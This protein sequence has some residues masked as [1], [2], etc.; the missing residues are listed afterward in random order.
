MTKKILIICSVMMIFCTGCSNTSRNSSTEAA[1]ITANEKQPVQAFGIVKVLNT[2]DIYLDFPIKIK[3]LLVKDGQTITGGETLAIIDSS[4]MNNEIQT[5]EDQA[6]ELGA[7]TITLQKTLAQKRELIF[8][9]MNPDILKLENVIKKA[10]AV[11]DN[12]LMEFTEKEALM[13]AGA[14]SQK[15]YHDY[16]T[17]VTAGRYACEDA[18][19]TLKSYKDALQNEFTRDE[20]AINQNLSKI[21]ALNMELQKSKSKLAIGNLKEN[22]IISD[23]PNGIVCSVDCSPGETVPSGKKLFSIMDADSLVIEANVDEQFIKDVHLGARAYIIPEWDR[24]Q[25]YKGKVTSI[26]AYAIQQNSETVIQVQ[27][28]LDVKCIG[29]LPGFNAEIS[30]EVE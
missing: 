20:A 27:V 25:E 10:Q 12:L 24:S 30:I 26:S 3:K 7:E 9:N 28:N 1:N 19:L 16:S 2:K 6:A 5:M 21:S 11:Y 13:E 18:E 29:L 17:Q 8:K 15:E 22:R 14:I 23:I 4:E